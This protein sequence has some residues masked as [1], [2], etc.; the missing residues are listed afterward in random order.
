MKIIS[1]HRDYYDGAR[2]YGIDPKLVYLR[3]RQE[4]DPR[5]VHVPLTP[6]QHIPSFHHGRY[7]SDNCT[8][9]V[10]VAFCGK[11]YTILEFRGR[12]YQTPEEIIRILERRRYATE[13]AV[14]SKRDA[15]NLRGE[16]IHSR[17]QHYP[18]NQH[19]WEEW[20]KLHQAKDIGDDPFIKMG[21]PVYS[22]EN[23]GRRHGRKVVVN[24]SLKDYMFQRI[25][26][27]WTAFQELSM[28]I[29]NNLAK[30]LQGHD[31]ISDEDMAAMKGFGHKYAFRKEP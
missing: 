16:K 2:G 27:P 14:L 20:C 9:Y 4:F 7:W 6:T 3:H 1:Q 23:Y 19:G 26:D 11:L 18:F 17:S 24:P 28:Y 30:E 5:D 12:F 29:G 13:P 22:F 31:Q 10:C 21:S 25:M 15:K 8:G